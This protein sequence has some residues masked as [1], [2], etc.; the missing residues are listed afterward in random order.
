MTDNSSNDE[1]GGNRDRTESMPPT[2]AD[3]ERSRPP[4]KI[5]QDHSH[6]FLSQFISVTQ[7][8]HGEYAASGPAHNFVCDR[9]EMAGQS[10]QRS[11]PAC[12]NNHQVGYSIG[13]AFRMTF[14]DPPNPF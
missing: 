9:S 13:T 12:P 2:P 11:G 6:C 4:R 7:R 10:W 5:R 3:G 14:G 1:Y 8:S